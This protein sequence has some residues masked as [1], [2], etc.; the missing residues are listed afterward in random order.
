MEQYIDR[1]VYQQHFESNKQLKQK[2]E[3]FSVF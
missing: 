1:F 2:F 3:I